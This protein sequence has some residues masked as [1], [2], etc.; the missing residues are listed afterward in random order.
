MP[1]YAVGLNAAIFN[2]SL[3]VASDTL[4]R[5][6]TNLSSTFAA[7]TFVMLAAFIALAAPV[8]PPIGNVTAKPLIKIVSLAVKLQSTTPVIIP[9]LPP[10]LVNR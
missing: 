6:I 4:T 3:I 1:V 5:L 10:P 7:C 2:L 9:Y 8:A